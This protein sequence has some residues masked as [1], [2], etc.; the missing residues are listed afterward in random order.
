LFEFLDLVFKIIAKD[1]F[2]GYGLF[3]IIYFLIFLIKGRV[4]DKFDISASR[5]LQFCGII[6]GICTLLFII[7][8]DIH[9]YPLIQA[10]IWIVITQLVTI[11]RV[12]KNWIARIVFAI[13]LIVSFEMYVIIVTSFHRDYNQGISIGL[14]APEIVIGLTGK[15]IIFCVLTLIY[16]WV[17]EFVIR[18]KF[19]R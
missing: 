1:F 17:R 11:D 13:L 6:Y 16:S 2:V 4:L 7:S 12:R 18:K 14:S 3:T 19:S 10:T 9:L 8:Y 15:V 5:F